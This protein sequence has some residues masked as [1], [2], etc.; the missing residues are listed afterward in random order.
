VS[1]RSVSIFYFG[2]LAALFPCLYLVNVV[3]TGIFVG[4][5]T[6][7]WGITLLCMAACTNFGGLA[8]VRLFLGIFEAGILPS[9]MVLQA[10]WWRRSEQ[11]LRTALWVSLNGS[12]TSPFCQAPTFFLNSRRLHPKLL[13]EI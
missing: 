4:T 7:L 8:T 5:V 11:A 10:K 12:D 9:F 1:E 2:Y 6:T 3:H 13:V